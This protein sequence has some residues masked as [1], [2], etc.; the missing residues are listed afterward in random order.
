MDHIA[1]LPPK[2][3]PTA[4][5]LRQLPVRRQTSK[6]LLNR[7]FDHGRTYDGQ[8]AAQPCPGVQL[9]ARV[10][11]PQPPVF[12]WVASSTFV[13]GAGLGRQQPRD[14]RPQ[15]WR[16]LVLGP[17]LRRHC[18]GGR[19][20]IAY[21]DRLASLAPRRSQTPA[22]PASSARLTQG[23]G[24]VNIASR[25]TMLPATFVGAP[26]TTSTTGNGRT[27]VAPF[28][29]FCHYS[30][31]HALKGSVSQRE[32]RHASPKAACPVGASHV[33]PSGCFETLRPHGKAVTL[34]KC[35]YR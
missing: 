26:S 4:V 24:L 6:P 22:S 10:S 12:V 18:L 16:S 5:A 25:Q 11:L 19:Q 33:R 31:L 23:Y 30:S 14:S 7:F 28:N 20:A 32:Q 9:H 34:A 27:R 3:P 29:G 8:G 15:R 35:L 13:L 1:P 21:P 2:F 17:V